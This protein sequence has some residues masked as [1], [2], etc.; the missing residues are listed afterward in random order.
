MFML[1]CSWGVHLRATP[2]WALLRADRTTSSRGSGHAPARCRRLHRLESATP[3]L[4]PD[5]A[6]PV[7]CIPLGDGYV[8]HAPG[9][10]PDDQLGSPRGRPGRQPGE[11]AA[12]PVLEI[13]TRYMSG[14]ALPRNQ[15]SSLLALDRLLC[16]RRGTRTGGLPCRTRRWRSYRPC[17]CRLTGSHATVGTDVDPPPG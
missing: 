9:G 15:R 13:G 5:A 2:S 3:G 8:L 6:R 4:E 12:T 1:A 10:S 11:S 16:Q 7:R 17:G 14:W